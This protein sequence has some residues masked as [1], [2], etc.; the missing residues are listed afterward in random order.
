MKYLLQKCKR[1]LNKERFERFNSETGICERN[2]P[3][4]WRL[5]SGSETS[6]MLGM[7]SNDVKSLD[8]DGG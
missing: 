3:C 6:C 5:G 8:A 2:N 4:L 1:N 7:T